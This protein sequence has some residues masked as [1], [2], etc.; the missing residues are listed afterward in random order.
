MT[1]RWGGKDA[2]GRRQQLTE[3]ERRRIVYFLKN[4]DEATLGDAERR[5]HRSPALLRKICKEEGID[6]SKFSR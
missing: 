4:T 1:T 2:R 6:T 5:F 3:E